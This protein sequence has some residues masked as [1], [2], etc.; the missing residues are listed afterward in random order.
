MKLT[1]TEMRKF[2]GRCIELTLQ[3]L[4]HYVVP[5]W[6]TCLIFA[7]CLVK[8]SEILNACHSLSLFGP[9]QEITCRQKGGRW[10]HSYGALWI[11]TREI[12]KTPNVCAGESSSHWI[13]KEKKCD[14]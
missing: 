8:I 11:T 4:A 5:V 3:M 14:S 1:S 6:L 7:L 9:L 13:A 2:V 12:W 10:T